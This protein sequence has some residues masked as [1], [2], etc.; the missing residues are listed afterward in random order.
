MNPKRLPR[1]FRTLRYVRASQLLWRMRVTAERRLRPPRTRTPEPTLVR[2]DAAGV[3]F[4]VMPEFH[5][6][7]PRGD[8]LLAELAQ[9]RF[10]HLD[11]SL[12]LGRERPDWLLGEA[13]TDRLWTIT[14]HYHGWA[15]G[16][17]EIAA[18]EGRQAAAAAELLTHYLSDWIE[19]CDVRARGARALAWN[20]FAIAT[21][22]TNWIR[23]RQLLQERRHGCWT[24][25]EPRFLDSLWRQA[26]YLHDHLEWDLRGNH[27]LRDLVGLAW[28][29][30]FFDG[31]QAARWSER[32]AALV[33]TQLA[34]QVLP[35]GAH[36]ERSPTY[37][38][39]VMEDVLS[40]ALL[41]EVP[42]I[43]EELSAVWLRMAGYL[44]WLRHPDGRVPL[45]NDG[46]M[47][48]L[49]EPARMLDLGR[50]LGLELDT[51]MP[52]GGILFP[53]AS[54]AA[55]PGV[56]CLSIP[57][58]MPTIAIRG[59]ATTVRPARTTRCVSIG[60]TRVRC[61]TCFVWGVARGRAMFV[62]RSKRASSRPWRRT[63]GLPTYPV[64]RLIGGVSRST[65]T[66]FCASRTSS[67]DAGSIG[68][69]GAY[70]ST[71]AGRRGPRRGAGG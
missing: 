7:G 63:T 60:P 10:S 15:H 70:C 8:E 34:E 3:G 26:A 14:L 30:R 6:V 13:A 41:L 42:E 2:P 61:G 16:L 62:P 9:G 4:P 19:R 40:L 31:G 37:H 33:L 44:R 38:L 47:H 59:D 67:R 65:T 50:H 36:F 18:G 49:C 69:P 45:L 57:A 43:V 64:G 29:G 46:G 53:D 21:R 71:H 66:A 54:S 11:R 17:A 55:L 24:E 58:P 12:D 32:A 25:L 28:A 20:S 1:L 23:V 48:S 35:D 52:E 51:S 56:A 39:H 5:R 27:L 22:I 68:S